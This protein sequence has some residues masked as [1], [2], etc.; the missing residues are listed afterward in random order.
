LHLPLAVCQ[1]RG[2]SARLFASSFYHVILQKPWISL[3]SDLEL[4][5]A[6]DL[7]GDKN[8]GMTNDFGL[9]ELLCLNGSFLEEFQQIQG[10]F[11]K[12]DLKI[13]ANI[14]L[15]MKQSKLRLSS[16]KISKENLTSQLKEIRKQRNE[17]R[18]TPLQEALFQLSASD[19]A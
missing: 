12:P 9:S 14:S 6:Q 19:I 15:L 3:P 16:S 10:L 7:E 17:S 11:N 5:F 4:R 1:L 8:N 13:H 18:K 2:N